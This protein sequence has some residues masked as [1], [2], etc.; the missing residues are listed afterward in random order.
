MVSQLAKR[1]IRRFLKGFLSGVGLYAGFKTVTALVK[2][3]FRERLPNIAKEILSKDCVRFAAFLGLYPSVYEFLVRT[4]HKIRGTKDGWNHGIAGGLAGLTI[5]LENPVRRRT[6]SLFTISRALGALVS[7]LITRGQIPSIVHGDTLLFCLSCSFLVYCTALRPHLLPKGY[8]YS[9]LKWS[10]DYTDDNLNQLFR[11]PGEKFL[12]CNEVGLHTDSCTSH[13][14]RDLIQSWPMFAK[15]YLPIHLAPVLIFRHKLLINRPAKVLRSLIK[16]TVMSTTF[17]ASMVM[18][19]KYV[20]CFLRTT[21]REP[22]P[23]RHYIPAVA[24]LVAGLGVL[25]ERANRR[26]ELVLFLIPH[27]LY[28]LFVWG[29]EKH[30][31]PWVPYSSVPLFALSTASIMHA[32]EREPDSMTPL[33]NGILRYFVGERVDKSKR[34]IKLRTESELM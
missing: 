10:R 5:V 25:F 11:V 20:V 28:A 9:V 13:A 30:I 24:G 23:L 3:P 22:P 17:L 29:M 1:F 33:I 32:Y 18:L 14:L 16:N 19:A 7:T 12:T 21:L 2:N 15:L 26:K 27:T 31:L 34:A 8:Y 4:I 6:L